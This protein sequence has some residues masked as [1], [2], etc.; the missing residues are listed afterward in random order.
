MKLVTVL[1][2]VALPLYCYAGTSGCSLLDNVIEKAV[3]P[4]VSK[5]EYREYLKDFA[6]TDDE[7]NAVDELKQCFLQQSNETLANFEQM[8]QIMYNSIYCK[9]F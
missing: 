8:L 4:T 6:R 7:K 9:A 3:D 5:D 2:L 1:M